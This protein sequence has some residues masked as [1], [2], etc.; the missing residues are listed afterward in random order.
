MILVTKELNSVKVL[1]SYLPR[2]GSGF[3]LGATVYI[4]I[5]IDR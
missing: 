2:F 4:D 3:L 1:N 5:D